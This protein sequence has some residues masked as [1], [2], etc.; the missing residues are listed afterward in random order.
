MYASQTFR[1]MVIKVVLDP[2]PFVKKER[3]V[4]ELINQNKL[5]FNKFQL[6]MFHVAIYP[7]AFTLSVSN[8]YHFS[9]IF[10]SPFFYRQIH[11]TQPY[12]SYTP[13]LKNQ[14]FTCVGGG[15]QLYIVKNIKVIHALI[16]CHFKSFDLQQKLHQFLMVKI[17]PPSLLRD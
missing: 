14:T 1:A 2:I 5:Q 8:F 10:Q 17:I 16:G 6:Q 3:L 12:Y 11:K 15:W 9:L 4:V 13:D 7:K